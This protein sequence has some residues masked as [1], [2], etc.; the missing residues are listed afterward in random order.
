VATKWQLHISVGGVVP[1]RFTA[2]N[3]NAIPLEKM[4]IRGIRS[5]NNGLTAA[6]SLSAFPSAFHFDRVTLPVRS[7]L[8]SSHE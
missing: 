7:L 2:R 4:N 6:N 8:F 1:V 3:G 5:R